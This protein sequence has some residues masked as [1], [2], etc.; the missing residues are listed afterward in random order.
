M[1]H[2]F[3]QILF[4]IFSLWH[5][6]PPT[7]PTASSTFSDLAAVSLPLLS[8]FFLS[9]LFSCFFFPFYSPFSLFLFISLLFLYPY[10][11]IVYIYTFLFIYILLLIYYII[12]Y[13]YYPLRRR[14]GRSPWGT[15]VFYYNLYYNFNLINFNIYFI[16][17]IIYLKYK[18]ILLDI[19]Y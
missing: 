14:G 6:H 8:F 7:P 9:F 17:F 11:L 1:L 18:Y 5:S 13:I 15:P 3:N 4:V 10:S 19:H 2:I 16:K 12:Y